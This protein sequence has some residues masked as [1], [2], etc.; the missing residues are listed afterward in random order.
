MQ[1]TF[2]QRTDKPD[3]QGRC[4]LFIDVTWPGQRATLATGVKCLPAH[5]APSKARPIATK[6]PDNARLNARLANLQL[7]ITKAATLAET[8]DESLTVAQLRTAVG[9]TPRATAAVVAPTMV[10]PADFHATWLTENQSSNRESARRYKQVVAHLDAFRP[11]WPVLT[12]TRADLASYLT[13]AADLGLV[14]STT[15]KHI[16]FLR[17]CFRLA[18][19]AVPTWLKMQVRYGRS[20]ALQAAELR[21]LLALPLFE[22]DALEQE[23]DLF[24]FQTLL[25][26]RDSDLR[27]LRPHH[28]NEMD[29]PGAGRVLVMS[30]R[31][32]KTGDEVRLPLPPLAAAIWLKYEGQLPMKVQQYRNRHMKQLME[33]AKLTRPFVRVRYQQGEATEEVVPLWQVVTTHTARHTGADMIM[34]G[35]GGDSNLKEKALGHASVYGHDALERYG[36]L[37]LQAWA[38][39]LSTS[40]TDNKKNPSKPQA[41]Q[42]KQP[43]KRVVQHLGQYT[44]VPLGK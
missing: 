21:Q 6:D 14:D 16:K 35:S 32:V 17:E 27:Q 30:L 44:L 29:L 19:L 34:L 9:A 24:L 42:I 33:R 37:V 38:A 3:R 40:K 22:Q 10:T 18:G 11:N 39:V 2:R 5:F 31:Q 7:K 36:P 43:V 26:L 15:V 8:N 12:L 20:P 28:V 1:L 25:L 23:R 4:Y 41:V 13:Y